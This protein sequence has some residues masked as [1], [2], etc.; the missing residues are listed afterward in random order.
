M[1]C[2]GFILVVVLAY[3]VSWAVTCGIIYLITLC[4]GIGFSLPMATGCWL[5]MLLI[6]TL[7][8]NKKK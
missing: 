8:K 4:F 5:I 1:N 6:G 2:L 3:L 7:F